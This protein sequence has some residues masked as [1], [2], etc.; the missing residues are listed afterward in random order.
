M[1]VD[2]IP[3]AGARF[4]S[5]WGWYLRR[6]L[7]VLLEYLLWGLSSALA[8]LAV[9]QLRTFLLIDIP[10]VTILR[11]NPWMPP[12][13]HYVGLALLGILWL[14]FVVLSESYFGRWMREKESRINIVKV[15]VIEG[16]IFGLAYAGHQLIK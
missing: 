12:V 1:R 13:I 8:L 9:L 3:L 4:V 6:G 11:Q 14:V 2:K 16:L 15:F 5:L 10:A 7:R